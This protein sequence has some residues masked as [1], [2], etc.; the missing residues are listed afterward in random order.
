M[1]PSHDSPVL[2]FIHVKT[3][4]AA[5]VWFVQGKKLFLKRI[6]HLYDIMR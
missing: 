2:D 3:M 6:T 5:H 4:Y 1:S